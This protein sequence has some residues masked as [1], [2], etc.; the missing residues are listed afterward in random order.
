MRSSS[1]GHTNAS[2]T[3][4]RVSRRKFGLNLTLLFLRKHRREN[5][6][7]ES[8][9]LQLLVDVLG[10]GNQGVIATRGKQSLASRKEA[11]ICSNGQ[12]SVWHEGPFPGVVKIRT[13]CRSRESLPMD[14][15]GTELDAWY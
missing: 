12:N 5:D 8:A 11:Y 14:A 1:F 10:R 3:S 6:K 7:V 15:E 13:V 4:G 2:N 9:G